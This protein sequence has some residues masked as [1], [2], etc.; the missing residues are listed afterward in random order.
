[1]S[2][3][4]KLLFKNRKFKAS[5]F[6]IIVSFFFLSCYKRLDRKNIETS[7]AN[8][9]SGFNI[10]LID[11][12]KVKIGDSVDNT[13]PIYPTRIFDRLGLFTVQNFAGYSKLFY[14]D[15]DTLF[16]VTYDHEG[17][18]G[19]GKVDKYALLLS[20]DSV[21]MTNRFFELVRVDLKGNLLDK[22]KLELGDTIMDINSSWITPLMKTKDS[23]LINVT[24]VYDVSSKEFQKVPLDGYFDLSEKKF[25]FNNN[26]YPYHYENGSYGI[27]SYSYGRVLT[28]NNELIYSFIYDP[29]F[30]QDFSE[31]ELSLFT[32]SRDYLDRNASFQ[33]A[34][35]YLLSNEQTYQM[36]YDN[37]NDLIIRLKLDKIEEDQLDTAKW[38]DKPIIAQFFKENKVTSHLFEPS[39]YSREG[40][41]CEDGILYMPFHNKSNPEAVEDYYV[42]HLFKI[43]LNE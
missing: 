6:L 40:I 26:R 12:L 22:Y 42:Y 5:Y 30:Y 37:K 7:Q 28:K 18:N 11:T 17:P 41:F 25:V 9:L 38:W 10:E 2:R 14:S 33:E 8:E 20:K 1:M 34:Y 16:S 13:G 36:I 23:I 32:G 29:N 3:Y 15:I 4:N 19:V 35:R 39:I 31:E 24:P 27:N 43:T 21:Y